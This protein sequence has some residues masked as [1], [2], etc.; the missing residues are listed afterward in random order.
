[1]LAMLLPHQ[2]IDLHRFKPEAQWAQS[3]QHN[4][5]LPHYLVASVLAICLAVAIAIALR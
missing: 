4:Q 5:L 1:M 2:T 3:P